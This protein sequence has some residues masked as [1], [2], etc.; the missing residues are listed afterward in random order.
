MDEPLS[1]LD[2]QLRSSMRAELQHLSRELKVT[3]IYVTHDQIEAMTLADR[4]AVMCEGEIR[5]LDRPE[6]IHNY[7]ADLFVAGFIGSP[8]MNLVPGEVRDGTFVAEG[9]KV[10]GVGQGSRQGIV[11][12]ARPEDIAV[13]DPEQ[14]HMRAEV[15]AFERTGDSALITIE[16]QG[17]H[18]TARGDRETKLAIGEN[19]GLRTNID[20]I[21]LFDTASGKLVTAMTQVNHK[22]SAV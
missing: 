7:P 3:T 18:F 10:P 11:L 6:T 4:V 22:E 8:P 16:V 2:A 15:Y 20:R 13:V 14:A 21:R 9:M 17:K 5:Q 12:G 1:N 19:V